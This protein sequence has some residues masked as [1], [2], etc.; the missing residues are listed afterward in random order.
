MKL[1]KICD[2]VMS[3]NFSF[4]EN[5]IGMSRAVVIKCILKASNFY[6]FIE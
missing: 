4:G 1:I 6:P 3:V 5:C 2:G